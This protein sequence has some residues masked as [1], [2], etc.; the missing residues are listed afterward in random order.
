MAPPPELLLVLLLVVVAGAVTVIACV[1][2]ACAPALSVST[3]C[4]VKLPAALVVTVAVGPVVPPL[5]AAMLLPLV[6]L[7]W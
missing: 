1:R 7:H 2:L 5:K 4:T 3:S 6:R